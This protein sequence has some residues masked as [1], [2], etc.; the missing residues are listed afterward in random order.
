MN[1]ISHRE[2]YASGSGRHHT[3]HAREE[4]ELSLHEKLLLTRDLFAHVSC[5]HAVVH[6]TATGDQ[7]YTDHS[8]ISTC[9]VAANNVQRTKLACCRP[10]NT[11]LQTVWLQWRSFL[12]L[13]DYAIALDLLTRHSTV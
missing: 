13:E 11:T 3:L 6:L 10:T 12:E 8:D 7:K 9:G 2:I 4:L 5:F 1:K